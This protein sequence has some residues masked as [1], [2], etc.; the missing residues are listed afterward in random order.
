[1]GYA[2]RDKPMLLGKLAAPPE[3]TNIDDKE[4]LEY[5]KGLSEIVASELEDV[6]NEEKN[7]FYLYTV[8]ELRN[9]G[10]DLIKWPP[11]KKL[12]MKAK[13][14]FAQD[15]MRISFIKGIALGFNFPEQFSIYWD[16]TYTMRFDSEWEE[17]RKR[18]IVLSEMQPKRT[19]NEAI[20]EMAES[21]IIWGTQ[22]V[23]DILDSQDIEI[24][25]SLIS[26]HKKE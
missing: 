11:D 1:L 6:K 14:G 23:P 21:A 3:I 9:I 24:L 22:E 25:K 16:N 26:H 15:V 17:M 7:F 4:I 18:G 20:A 12:E 5:F 8:R 10:I 13:A 2:L 19:R